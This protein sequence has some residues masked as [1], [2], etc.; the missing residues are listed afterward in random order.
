MFIFST[1]SVKDTCS[2]L[3]LL[4]WHGPFSHPE[5]KGLVRELGCHRSTSPSWQGDVTVPCPL[6]TGGAALPA[7]FI[8][9]LG[10]GRCPAIHIDM[11]KT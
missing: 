3:E 5:M 11:E 8:Q 1:F 10:G 4:P 7:V 2:E 9:M 6:A